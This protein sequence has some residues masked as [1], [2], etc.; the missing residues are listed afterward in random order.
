MTS[1]ANLGEPP[2]QKR[3]V[4]ITAV[5]KVDGYTHVHEKDTYYMVAIRYF[6]LLFPSDD[7]YYPLS[8]TDGN[9]RD[10]P[11]GSI[12]SSLP[13]KVDLSIVFM[14]VKLPEKG[15]VEFL[16]GTA[17]LSDDLKKVGTRAWLTEKGFD[18]FVVEVE[19]LPVVKGKTAEEVSKAVLALPKPKAEEKK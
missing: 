4:A 3:V 7:I 14:W 15:M 13:G 9:M 12:G 17:R 1:I 19:N 5:V 10:I 16:S 8:I 11:F 2:A 6:G 18:G